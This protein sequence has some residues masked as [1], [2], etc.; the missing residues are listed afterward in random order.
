MTN[1]YENQDQEIQESDRKNY[2]IL[3]E[4]KEGIYDN[5]NKLTTITPEIAEI[6]CR[7]EGQLD[8]HSL[9]MIPDEAMYYLAQY[10]KVL[11]LPKIKA[12]SIQGLEYLSH[13]DN[14]LLLTGIKHL[15][16]E[17][18]GVLKQHKKHLTIGLDNI[19]EEVAVELSQHEGDLELYDL[20]E[21][22]QKTAEAFSKHN[23]TLTLGLNSLTS[24]V[25]LFLAP[26]KGPLKLDL[27]YID[28]ESMKNLA[29]HIGVMYL[30]ELKE[31]S[32]GSAKYLAEYHE[33]EIY[34][35]RL[36]TITDKVA[37]ILVNHK[38]KIHASSSG[39]V[40]TKIFNNIKE[41]DSLSDIFNLTQE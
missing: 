30:N 4:I 16:K 36:M 28:D 3:S 39:D 19:D 10:K 31:L 14:S 5:L 33:G 34:V 41:D 2:E 40:E 9:E 21:I 38:G 17:Q 13:H 1:T 32:E 11:Y 37:K 8:L 29:K 12:F 23:G 35:S 25:A 24:E 27:E 26:H 20:K 15:T 18:A 7:Y 22:D 6:I